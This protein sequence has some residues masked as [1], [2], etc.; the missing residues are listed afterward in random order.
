MRRN[1][2][3]ASSLVALALAGVGAA[4]PAAAGRGS[5]P[6][7]VKSAIA[8]DSIDAIASELERAEYLVCP[9]CIDM[10]RPLVDHQ[11]ARV[12]RVAAWWLARRGVRQQVYVDMVR[13]LGGSDSTAARNAAD[14]L[15]E[16]RGREAIG[17]LGAAIESASLSAEARAAAAR[18][19][20]TIGD[21][22]A[23]GPLGRALGAGEAEVREAALVALRG[24]RGLDDGALVAPLL[25]DPDAS[26]RIEAIYT[27]G[28]WRSKAGVSGLV[29][30]LG[31]P[32]SAVRRKA[33]WGLG[34]VGASAVEAGPALQKVAANDANPL[35]R[36]IAQ[37]A[38]S[39]LT[40]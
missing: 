19:L 39:R 31:D 30:L 2:K 36:S 14:V 28:A 24:L 29:K 6:G 17:P 3:I 16:M 10:V 40:R 21:P 32:D 9:S 26:V 34:E 5:S 12:R 4:S 38:I 25:G 23:R 1:L 35:V 11:D 37:A 22:D 27:L 20:G 7:A 18:A 33:A 8:S 13:R 15:G